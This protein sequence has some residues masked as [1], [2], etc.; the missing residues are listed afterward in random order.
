MRQN[1]KRDQ[2]IANLIHGN[3]IVS[4]A[5]SN[6]VIK[7]TNDCDGFVM[8]YE[9][10]MSNW[11]FCRVSRFYIG[12]YSSVGT[13]DSTGKLLE[14][15]IWAKPTLSYGNYGWLNVRNVFA[16]FSRDSNIGGLA[17]LGFVAPLQLGI[18]RV[19]AVRLIINK[20]WLMFDVFEPK[21]AIA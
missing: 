17:T 9:L 5:S 14:T 18:R 15:P 2:Q 21:F 4:T 6:T 8:T 12:L 7:N 1:S 10:G 20:Y 19:C 3:A 16:C 13:S 11:A